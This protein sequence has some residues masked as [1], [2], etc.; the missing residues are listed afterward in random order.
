[1]LFPAP[2]FPGRTRGPDRRLPPAGSVV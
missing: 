2:D 1:V